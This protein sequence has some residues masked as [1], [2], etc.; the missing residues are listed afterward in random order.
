MQQYTLGTY[1]FPPTL[2]ERMLGQE[3]GI[4]VT[5]EMIDVAPGLAEMINRA[6]QRTGKGAM[7]HIPQE[8]PTHHQ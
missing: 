1:F 3:I 6:R 8:G 5:Q 2:M 4:S 7:A